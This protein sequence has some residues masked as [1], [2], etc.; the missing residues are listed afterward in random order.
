MKQG[1]RAH[2]AEGWKRHHTTATSEVAAYIVCISCWR[3]QQ[4]HMLVLHKVCCG[5][6]F[7]TYKGLCALVSA[8]QRSLLLIMAPLHEETLQWQS[9]VI[10]AQIPR[11][12]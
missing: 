5:S 8:L 1:W 4:G 9:L 11:G 2:P 3:L 12:K 10:I 6:G 7:Y